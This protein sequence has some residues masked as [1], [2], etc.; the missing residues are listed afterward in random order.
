MLEKKTSYF[1]LA[2]ADSFTRESRVVCIEASVEDDKLEDEAVET[3][4]M[5]II[6]PPKVE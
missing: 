5:E 2:H 4:E 1:S 6:T 3:G